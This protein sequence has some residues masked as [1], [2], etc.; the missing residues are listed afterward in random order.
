MADSDIK[1]GL[2]SA[3]RIKLSNGSYMTGQVACKTSKI[4]SKTYHLCI[5]EEAQD[6]DDLIVAKSI[7][8]MMTATLG[9]L[10]KVG[11]TGVK[12]GDFFH[13]IQRN[14][15]RS[16]KKFAGKLRFHFQY[17][18][19][20]IIRQKRLQYEKDGKLFHLNYEK[21]IAQQIEKRGTNNE[22]FKLAYA[23]IWALDAGMFISDSEW[24]S[25]INKHKVFIRTI[26]KKWD[27]RAGLD[28][29]KD[30]ASTVLTIGKR[31]IDEKGK[32]KKEVLNIID[33]G[34]MGY[35]EQYNI[36]SQAI[37]DY[38]ITVL[39]ADYTGVGRPVVDRFL[40]HQGKYCEIKPYTFTRQSKSDMWVNLRMAIEN[41]GIEIPAHQTIRDMPE[42]RKLEE[43]MK[44]MVKYFEG[45]FMV[46]HKGNDCPFDD[47]C[48][49]LGLF[50]LACEVEL[51]QRTDIIENGE[52]P[53]Y[54]NS[55][56]VRNIH[57][58]GWN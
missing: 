31:Y 48:D 27:I 10:V 43:Q 49:S 14:S 39:M 40:V 51:A 4:E 1:T 24:N 33:L 34:G 16:V 5:I 13:E 6:T 12:K 52:N 3:H 45:S 58:S 11:T 30:R 9:T 54:P 23:L 32:L 19:L 42:Y 35:E 37:D 7:E 41:R 46:A 47:Y 25:I 53:F 15:R 28:I 38:N 2:V 29:A 55:G 26:D 44:G 18:Y 22:A 20:E 57:E 17:N 56:I 50:S 21:F 36:L 8:P